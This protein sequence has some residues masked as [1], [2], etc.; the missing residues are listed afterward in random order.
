NMGK[1]LHDLGDFPKAIRAY[2]KAVALRP[3]DREALIGLIGA[4][5][6]TGASDQAGPWVA[7][8]ARKFP[9][10]PVIL[11]FA[12]RTAFDANRLDE[13]IALAD[14]ALQQDPRN[15]PALMARARCRIA[16]SCWKEAL[17]DVEQAVAARPNNVAALQL[18]L[19]I[20]THLGLGQR[21]AA[22]QA[23]R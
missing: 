11:G 6:Y 20:E 21:A 8:A 14:R 12:A 18:L 23:R 15:V 3:D 16:R 5:L 10:D 4:L 7:K 2:E 9:H 17:T 1:V 13:A 22:T 19:M